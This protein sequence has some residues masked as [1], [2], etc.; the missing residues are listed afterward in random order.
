MQSPRAADEINEMVRVGIDRR[1]P[2]VAVPPV[3][4]WKQQAERFVQ[5]NE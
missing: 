3:G 4:R 2:D 5:Q 1:I